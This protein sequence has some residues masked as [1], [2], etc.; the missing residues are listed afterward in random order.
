MRRLTFVHLII[1][2]LFFTARPAAAGSTIRVYYAGPQDS[3]LRRALD[4]TGRADTFA[5]VTDP[6][7]ADVFLL[8]GLIPDPMAIA[9][10]LQAGAGLVLIIGPD[11]SQADV[12]TL[13]GIP[14]T[15]VRQDTPVS[16]TAVKG[17]DDP[18]TQEVV[19]NGS[20]QIRERDIVVTPV[21]S[22]QPLIVGYEDSSWV[23]WSAR[24]GKAFI[25]NG[26]LDGQFNP[27]I[28]EW[29]YFNYLIYHLTVRAAGADTAFLCRLSRLAGASRPRAGRP[30]R[31]DGAYV[32]HD[33]HRIFHRA[34]LQLETPRGAG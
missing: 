24:Q 15:L 9:E 19:W 13:L 28:Q 25:F 26:F 29:A 12:Q 14:V 16:L 23:L 33:L 2:C 5:L 1:A 3:S 17:M 20:P 34:P 31:A 18:V 30:A 10:R 11:L 32:G 21:S 7:Q 4:L 6:T 27:Q 22:V 8:N